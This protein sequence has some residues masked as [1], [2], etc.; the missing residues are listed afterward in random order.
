MLPCGLFDFATILNIVMHKSMVSL[1]S[2]VV[3]VNTEGRIILHVLRIR[4][5][6]FHQ[7]FFALP[8][9]SYCILI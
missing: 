7:P 9:K 6:Y 3:H 1:W 4:K 5:V 2:F 8:G